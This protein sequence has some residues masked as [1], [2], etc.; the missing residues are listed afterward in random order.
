M[1]YGVHERTEQ[2]NN[3]GKEMKRIVVSFIGGMTTFATIPFFVSPFTCRR[4]PRLSSREAA[5]PDVAQYF[6]VTGQYISDACQ[7]FEEL[8]S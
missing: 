8:H 3:M 4:M 6:G 5:K 1:C 7:K 2:E